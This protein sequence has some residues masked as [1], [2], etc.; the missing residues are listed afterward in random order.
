M[1]PYAALQA[2]DFR[3]PSYSESDATGSGFALTTSL[4]ALDA[5]Q[6]A[7]AAGPGARA[8]MDSAGTFLPVDPEP[9]HMNI[10]EAAPPLILHLVQHAERS[11]TLKQL[12]TGQV[13]I[14]GGWIC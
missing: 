8:L 12:S 4:G 11:I 5:R 10:T 14:G 6:V 1:T 13:V 7:V 3:T 2:Q 9:L